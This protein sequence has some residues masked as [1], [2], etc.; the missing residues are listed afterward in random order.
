[1]TNLPIRVTWPVLAWL[2]AMPMLA[3]A[4]SYNGKNEILN[5]SIHDS[6]HAL[7]LLASASNTENCASPGLGNLIVIPNTNPNFKLMYA[8]AL[9]ALSTGRPVENW[10]NGCL[11]IWGT[12]TNRGAAGDHDDGGEVAV[13]RA[14]LR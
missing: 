13:G 6:G 12:G 1:M 7:V 14:V 3:A 9:L 11:D 5:V 10:V 2:A 8:T 4:N